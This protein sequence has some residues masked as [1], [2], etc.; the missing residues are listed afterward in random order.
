MGLAI[1]LFLRSRGGKWETWGLFAFQALPGKKRFRAP[2]DIEILR[3]DIFFLREMD[4]KDGESFSLL[5]QLILEI[6]E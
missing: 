5:F 6:V 1:I 3:E 2:R 4:W